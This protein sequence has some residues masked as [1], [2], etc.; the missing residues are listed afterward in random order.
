MFVAIYGGWR[1]GLLAT[2]LSAILA[3]YFWVEPAG[4]FAL[5]EPAGWLGLAIFLL[6]GCMIAWISEALH[7]ARTRAYAAETQALLAAEREAAAELL[8]KSEERYHTL[9][10]GMTEGFAVHELLTDESGRPVD[11]RFLDV[12]PA[13]ERLTGL[14]RQDVV[15]RTHNVVL[16]GDDPKWLRMYGHVALTGQPVQFENYSPVLK[17]HYEVFAYR[18]APMQFAVIFMDI[19]ER[20]QAEEAL[21]LTQASIDDAA[22]MV[23]WFTPDGKVRYANDATCQTLG[24]SR[25]ELM[26]LTSLD[27]CPGFTWEQYCEHWREVRRRKS[28]T[29][30]VTHRR[31]DGSEYPAEVLVNHIEYGGQEY[32][33]AYGRDITERK[34][35]EAELRN[36]RDALESKWRTPPPPGW[37]DIYRPPCRAIS[38]LR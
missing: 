19:T 30:E 20:K 10:T 14:E 33:F 16:P 3:D 23:A 12:N 32:I 28:F 4:Q 13:F 15:G 18:P 26:T 37:R 17:R 24:Y 34:Q 29:L 36:S 5:G 2:V 9:F 6:S 21:R 11:Y 27:F 31:K 22:E 7:R 8:R 1:A 38:I 25:D 35:M